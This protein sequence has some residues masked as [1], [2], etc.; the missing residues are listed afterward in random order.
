[1]GRLRHFW[2]RFQ[3]GLELWQLVWR[4]PRTPHAARWLPGQAVA[5]AV[6]PFGFIP[7]FIPS[8]DQFDELIIVPVLVEPTV[9][10]VSEDVMG[11]CRSGLAPGAAQG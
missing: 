7:D 4:P 8:P 3:D 5:Y 9:R 1:M 11:E 10:L 2:H 6:T